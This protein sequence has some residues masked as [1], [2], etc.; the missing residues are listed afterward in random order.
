MPRSIEH[1]IIRKLEKAEKIPYELLLLADETIE[2]IN[3]YI[4]NS[5]IY[6]LEQN[7]TAIAVYALQRLSENE[8]EI[9]NIA[10]SA[11]HR[12]QGI[13]KQLIEDAVKRAT[14][15]GYKAIVVGTG[16]VSAMP[17][18]FYLKQGFEVFGVRKNFFIDK[19]TEP[20]YENGIRLVD[21][22]MLKK[23]I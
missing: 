9:E 2:G 17:L 19:Y 21:M 13:G 6:V 5:E 22:V 4:F 7:R 14:I 23:S 12:R 11:A 15:S 8:V 1:Q 3:K 10:V 18:Q 20:I 16:D